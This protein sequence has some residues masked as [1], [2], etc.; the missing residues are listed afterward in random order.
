MIR[1][2]TRC[3]GTLKFDATSGGTVE[4]FESPAGR[5]DE[6]GAS[7]EGGGVVFFGLVDPGFG[8]V[9]CA[10]AMGEFV[11]FG[12]REEGFVG[13]IVGTEHT[14]LYKHMFRK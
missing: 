8:D 6:S 9:F 11:G 14:L 10:D 13:R 7:D 2:A 3:H 4:T 12:G 1:S 5:G